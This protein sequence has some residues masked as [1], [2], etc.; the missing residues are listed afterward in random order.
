MELLR[1]V[2][3]GFEAP[4]WKV[5]MTMEEIEKKAFDWYVSQGYDPTDIKFTSCGTP[6]FMIGG[7]GVEVK[8]LCKNRIY[9][10]DKQLEKLRKTD[11]KIAVFSRDS[12]SPVMTINPEQVKENGGLV[13]GIKINII[14]Q[15]KTIP[16]SD[17]TWRV[18][19]H[20]KIEADAKT[21][22]E[23]VQLLLKRCGLFCQTDMLVRK[24]L[25]GS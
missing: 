9:I 21:Y 11:G 16:L 14:K 23:A 3:V 25:K 22:D 5:D 7:K 13:Q 12:P 8:T 19:T 17:K 2:W 1:D 20:I 4:R 18:L 10:T 15:G 24:Q 6:D